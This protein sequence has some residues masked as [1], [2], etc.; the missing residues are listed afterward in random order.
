MITLLRKVRQQLFEQGKF[1]E[2]VKYAIG[3]IILVMIGI[4]LALQVNN[5]NEARKDKLREHGILTALYRD[6]QGNIEAFQPLMVNQQNTFR[7]GEIVLRNIGTLEIG[8]SRDSVYQYA[9]GMFG[10][11]PY[12]PS[13]G[14]VQS[15][16]SSGDINLIS[17][18]T[19]KNYL[20]SWSDVLNRYTS[21]VEIDRQ[22][23]TSTI[24]PYIMQHGDFTNASSEK[25]K[26]LLSDPVFINMLARKQF[27]QRNIIN[28]I[29]DENGLL[30]YL[31]EI[32]RLSSA[33]SSTK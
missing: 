31:K 19:L 16:I 18:D 9:T 5:W 20:V 24:E 29:Q 13:N 14:V 1:G 2:Y 27:F 23:W 15:L 17:N 26:L 22:L 32:V 11:Y 6:F 21:N 8:A 10:G 7:S 12:Y 30:H 3:E 28:A 33:G 25:N 4:L